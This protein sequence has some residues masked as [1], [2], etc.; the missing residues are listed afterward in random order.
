MEKHVKLESGIDEPKMT[1]ENKDVK[2]YFMWPMLIAIITFLLTSLFWK[3]TDSTN[4]EY[5]LQEKKLNII[6]EFSESFE[7]YNYYSG[8][9]GMIDLEQIEYVKYFKE[10]KNNNLNFVELSISQRIE[11]A[12]S[13]RNKYPLVYDKM[14]EG[15]VKCTSFLK[16]I[17]LAQIF[18]SDSIRA[19]IND[20]MD[21]IPIDLKINGYIVQRLKS[22]S[23]KMT[24]HE[25]NVLLQ[26]IQVETRDKFSK[27]L[28]KMVTEVK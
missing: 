17:H 23:T 13:M 20:F 4:K 16:N 11:L 9:R 14:M 28:N 6:S 5:L 15:D 1:T 2:Q 8:F 27:I 22:D 7:T 24:E 21:Y 26:N 12:D 19:M 25:K 18:F 10:I 3:Y